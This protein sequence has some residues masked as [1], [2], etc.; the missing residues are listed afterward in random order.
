MPGLSIAPIASAPQTPLE[1]PAGQIAEAIGQ[2]P[3]DQQKYQLQQAE[4]DA[5]GID[6]ASKKL[7]VLNKLISSNLG[8]ASSPQMIA[9]AQRAFQGLGMPAPMKNVNGVPSL[10]TD[11]LY[12]FGPASEFM[13]Q[14]L[15]MMLSF[16]PDQRGALIEA[17][18][19]QTLPEGVMQRLSALPQRMISTPSELGGLYNRATQAI[20]NLR[21]PGATI[22]GALAVIKPINEVLR[23]NGMPGVDVEDLMGAGLHQALLNQAQLQGMDAKS[24]EQYAQAGLAKVRTELAPTYAAA[25]TTRANASMVSANASASRAATSALRAPAEIAR[26]YAE[27]DHAEAQTKELV[28]KVATGGA[29][30][31]DLEANANNAQSLVARLEADINDPTQGLKAQDA[32]LDKTAPDYA[33]RHKE[34]NDTIYETEQR[35]KAARKAAQTAQQAFQQGQAH[36]HNGTPTSGQPSSSEYTPGKVYTYPDGRKLKYLGGDPHQESSWQPQ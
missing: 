19:G 9:A 14:N 28:Q 32:A 26:D 29:T 16:P 12:S 23:Q 34:L 25:A 35:I 2:F 10:D 7:A 21:Y 5:Q 4:I 6:N 8:L 36:L 11:A 31:K 22:E 24:A 30:L 3:Q 33:T 20:D 15:G 18:T 1:S 27:A 17:A 13:A